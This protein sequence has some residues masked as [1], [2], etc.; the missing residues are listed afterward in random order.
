MSEEEKLEEAETK[1][2]VNWCRVARGKL[3]VNFNVS[4]HVNSLTYVMCNK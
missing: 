4:Y 2:G 1:A 3:V